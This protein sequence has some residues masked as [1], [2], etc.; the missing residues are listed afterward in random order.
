MIIRSANTT[1]KAIQHSFWQP[2]ARS[3]YAEDFNTCAAAGNGSQGLGIETIMA[4]LELVMEGASFLRIEQDNIF[5][6]F[7]IVDEEHSIVKASKIRYT[8]KDLQQ[9]FQIFVNQLV[10]ADYSSL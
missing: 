6:G 1:M 10:H 2:L 9:D 7:A 3:V 8:K 4:Q 5:I